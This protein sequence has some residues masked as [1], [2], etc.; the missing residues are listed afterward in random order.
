ME[1]S[2]E[3]LHKEHNYDEITKRFENYLGRY[4]EIFNPRS[5]TGKILGIASKAND[6]NRTLRYLTHS[7]DNSEIHQMRTSIIEAFGEEEMY[8]VIYLAF[9]ETI[10]RFDP[11]RGV[12]MEKF[13]YNYYPYMITNEVNRLAGPK[14]ILN[15]EKNIS[16]LM[17]HDNYIDGT[18]NIDLSD[19][20]ID[21][22][23]IEG[24]TCAEPFTVLTS[25]ERKMLVMMFIDNMT[26]EEIANIMRYHFSSIKRKKNLIIK[27]LSKRI[28]KLEEEELI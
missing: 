13:I 25:L 7:S 20:I 1:K 4:K 2:L 22:K 9:I 27:K 19:V 17:E 24:E 11:S 28:K 6:I 18:I 8:Q 26:Q 10:N 15:N 14:Q 5:T 21:D 23:W 16:P 3:E 12:P